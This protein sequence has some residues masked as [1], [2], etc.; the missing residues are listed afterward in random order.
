MLALSSA[1][2]SAADQQLI[3]TLS[4]P[5]PVATALLQDLHSASEVSPNIVR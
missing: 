5:L 3:G 4:N 1:K 2:Y